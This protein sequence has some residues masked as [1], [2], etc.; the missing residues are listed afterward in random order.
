VKKYHKGQ[1]RNCN[2]SKQ[3]GLEVTA[4]K[5]KSMSMAHHQNTGQ[6]H[7]TKPANRAFKKVAKFKYLGL[8]VIHQKLIHEK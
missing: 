4:E 6:N 1:H 3:V 7:K 5:A 2:A 8:R